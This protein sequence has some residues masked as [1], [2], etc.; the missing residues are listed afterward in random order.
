M[1]CSYLTEEELI[2]WEQFH[3]ASIRRRER[4]RFVCE[5]LQPKE[6]SFSKASDSFTYL[7]EPNHN[8]FLPNNYPH[9]VD[10]IDILIA[11]A[12]KEYNL[13]VNTKHEYVIQF[14]V[15]LF[16]IEECSKDLLARDNY[17]LFKSLDGKF[18]EADVLYSN[19]TAYLLRKYKRLRCLQ[20]ERVEAVRTL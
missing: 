8:D 11:F 1:D 4:L 13:N 17:P 15:N 14:L 9:L 5:I 10:C 18:Y 19:I 6:Y 3:K 2:L 16:S 20:E 12:N 7:Y